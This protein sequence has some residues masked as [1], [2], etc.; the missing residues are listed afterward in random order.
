MNNINE[1]DILECI[2][3]YGEYLKY[4]IISDRVHL[5]KS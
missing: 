2:Y 1:K 4:I 3:E 5:S